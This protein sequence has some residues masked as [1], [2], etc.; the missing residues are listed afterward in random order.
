M[1]FST[2]FKSNP[3][4]LA[5]DIIKEIQKNENILKIEIAGPGFINFFTS[6]DTKFAVIGKN[7]K[8]KKFIWKK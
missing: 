7:I 3:K 5:E 4:K 8:R 6:K 1:K 2:R